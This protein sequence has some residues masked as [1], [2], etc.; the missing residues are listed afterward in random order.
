MN[1][2]L[3]NHYAG[4]P[5][6][7]MEF[8]P[9]YLA[10]AWQQAGHQV[11]I[12]GATYSHLRKQQ[13]AG[14]KD[15][16]DGIFYH[17]VKVN[18]YGGNGLG[19]VLSM[20]LFVIQLQFKYKK[21]LKGFIP[22]VVIA[23]STYPF[24]IYPARKIAQ[25]YKAKL[26]YEIHDLWPLS[27]M[28]IGGYSKHHPFMAL[29]QHAENYAYKYS[30]KVVSLLWNAKD[31]AVSH[32]MQPQKFACIP[33]GYNAADW[34]DN[35]IDIPQEHQQL[36]SQLKSEGKLI[37]GYSG[38]HT[39]ST[40]LHVLVDAAQQLQVNSE[41]AFVLVGSGNTKDELIQQAQQLSL[42]NIYFLPSVDKK[43]IPHLVTQFDIAFMGGTHSILHK[44]GTSFN[45]MADYMLSS[46][47][48]VCAVDEPNNLI[49]KL[50]CGIR[51]E[52]ENVQQLTEAIRTL[53][54]ILPEERA[55]M[56][57]KGHDYA[58]QHLNYTTLSQQFIEIMQSVLPNLEAKTR[59]IR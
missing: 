10:K 4:S 59:Q 15:T 22:D 50:E 16:I 42:Q 8:R 7:G 52:A 45:K 3:I 9:Y 21:Y 56:G 26:V 27:P 33:N 2:L 28:L 39:Q 11:R 1:I 32:G 54:K 38:G 37:V 51:V 58:A 55:A 57:K 23:S 40:A 25:K 34:N 17:W 14:G 43:S 24:D 18:S 47:P 35:R 44:Y 13:P 46:K 31:H 36:F 12:V 29:M 6:L 41:L 20:F 30:D 48:I 53:S 19:R 49:E 5:Q